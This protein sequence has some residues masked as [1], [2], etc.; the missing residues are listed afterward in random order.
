MTNQ[1]LFFIFNKFY[2]KKNY[3]IYTPNIRLNNIIL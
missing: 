3:G 2:L 1:S